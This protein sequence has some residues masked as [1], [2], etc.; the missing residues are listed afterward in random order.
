MLIH[1]I[2]IQ[3][4]KDNVKVSFDN[5]QSWKTY[6]VTENGTHV[7]DIE[8]TK[9]DCSNI[10]NIIIGSSAR[11]KPNATDTMKKYFDLETV[12]TKYTT[13]DDF[14]NLLSTL[15]E[16]SA[17]NPYSIKIK[18][19]TEDN[20]QKIR[21]ALSTINRKIYIDLSPSDLRGC[22]S[23]FD[24]SYFLGEA[25]QELLTGITL[26]EDL[27]YIGTNVF[28]GC[29]NLKAI[30]IPQLVTD[31]G[32]KAFY[33]CI[34]LEEVTLLT[35]IKSIDGHAFDHD[36]DKTSKLSKIT[37]LG[38]LTRWSQVEKEDNDFLANAENV[39]TIT[40]E[41]TIDNLEEFLNNMESSPND[42]IP[43]SVGEVS[44]ADELKKIN[45][46][47][48]NAKAFVDLSSLDLS[49]FKDLFEG[50][51]NDDSSGIFDTDVK[52]YIVSLTV[53]ENVTSIGKYVFSD[54]RNMT[55]VFFGSKIEEIKQGAFTNCSSLTETA[56]PKSLTKIGFKA[57]YNCKNIRISC[58]YN[59]SFTSFFKDTSID[60]SN[61]YKLA[62]PSS[63]KRIE[64]GEFENC[65]NLV[66]ITIPESVIDIGERAFKNCSRLKT[67]E[68][69]SGVK[70]IS[71]S[72]FEGCTYLKSVKLPVTLEK[73]SEAAFY[74]CINLATIIWKD[75]NKLVENI[76]GNKL[77][78]IE[79]FAFKNCKS[80]L[81][82]DLSKSNITILPEGCFTNC[83]KITK[84]VLPSTLTSIN[85]KAFYS[86]VS[87]SN[88]SIPNNVNNIG[89]YVFY[90]TSIKNFTFPTSLKTLGVGAFKRTG[91]TEISL[92]EGFTN[93]GEEC[94]ME[95]KIESIQL[96]QSLKYIDANAF[97]GCSNLKE[98]EL[99][100][101]V[102]ELG[103]YAFANCTSLGNV[104]IPS[105]ITGTKKI[106]SFQDDA[107]NDIDDI[108]IIRMPID[109]GVKSDGIGLPKTSQT[110]KD[111]L[112]IP[113][114][115]DTIPNN[116]FTECSSIE[117]V[118]IPENIKT[119]GDNA[120]ENCTN[121]KSIYLPKSIE[122]I[123]FNAFYYCSNLENVYYQGTEEEWKEL[124]TGWYDVVVK[125]SDGTILKD[126]NNNEL[127]EKGIKKYIKAGNDNLFKENIVYH[128]NTVP[129]GVSA[130]TY[131]PA[132]YNFT[133]KKSYKNYKFLVDDNNK[134]LS[135]SQVY[136]LSGYTELNTTVYCFGIGAFYNCPNLC[137]TI[138]YTDELANYFKDSGISK[139]NGLK[140]FVPKDVKE[141]PNGI[142]K[143][144][145]GLNNVTFDPDIKLEKIGEY[146]FYNCYSISS[147]IIPT[148]VTYIGKYAFKGCKG[149]KSIELNDITKVIREGTF[150]GC[151]NLKD[152]D[153]PEQL[154][155]IET[156]AFYD[157]TSLEDITFY[158]SLKEI[159]TNA[160]YNCKNVRLTCEYN[161]YYSDG[162][163]GWQERS[164]YL[165]ESGLTT[166]NVYKLILPDKI[167]EIP[168]DEFINEETVLHGLPCQYKNL[169]SIV[170]TKNIKKIG[171]RAFAY[172]SNL[173][174]III[175][176]DCVITEICEDAFLECNSLITFN[177]T[178]N[179]IEIG[180]DAFSLCGFKE[181]NLP[182]SIIN[183]D[184]GA[185]SGCVNLKKIKMPKNLTKISKNLFLGDTSLS[186][187]EI[188]QNV[189]YYGEECFMGCTSLRDFTLR[190]N[191]KFVGKDAF[192]FCP[193]IRLNCYYNQYWDGIYATKGFSSSQ[194]Y[195]IN[196]DN[197]M[198]EIPDYKF[199]NFKSLRKVTFY[200]AGTS[201]IKNIG[202]GAFRGCTSLFETE[203]PRSCNTIQDWAYAESG[204]V[205]LKFP[206]NLKRIAANVCFD[207][208]DLETVSFDCS[209]TE[210]C[211]NA[212]KKCSKLKTITL[213]DSIRIMGKGL[214][215]ECSSLE[216]INIPASSGNI[217]DNCFYKCTSLKNIS[218]GNNTTII[219]NGT[220]SGCSS[221][222]SIRLPDNLVE[223]DNNCFEDCIKLKNINI[224]NT[225]N[226]IGARAFFNCL[227]L[228]N[229]S[230]PSTLTE[231]RF[232]TF[233]NCSA[234]GTITIPTNVEKV[235]GNVFANCSSLIIN[236]GSNKNFNVSYNGKMITNKD[237]TTLFAFI[238]YTTKT[239][240]IP[241]T[242]KKIG[243]GALKDCFKLVSV[244]IPNG[245]EYIDEYSF[246]GCINLQKITLP[247][248]ILRIGKAAFEN[249]YNLG[250]VPSTGIFYKGTEEKWKNIKINRDGNSVIV[251]P[252]QIN[253]GA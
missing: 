161:N 113:R 243:N 73:I 136:D 133:R 89:D 158:G 87:L 72:T 154:E 96:P 103:Y 22:P 97:N 16:N 164:K 66:G 63:L 152:I 192:A 153:Y 247:T 12:N 35:S 181:V 143:N 101:G 233:E 141:L 126:K 75:G 50:M 106:V 60:K 216:S 201:V 167:T 94:F 235:E 226:E 123:D 49:K 138:T 242:I 182:D 202:V 238:D 39:E 76:A 100:E 130:G 137:I 33:N 57:F 193:D 209:P 17:S 188:P 4:T 13:P 208:K 248:T 84:I 95:S 198:T 15:S 196:V 99:K 175:P 21:E 120:F 78:L 36:A 109:I 225:V 23:I 102:E 189:T 155:I 195:C 147:L 150:E 43:I 203:P 70:N 177:F 38:S 165:G 145:T 179:L 59:N 135:V 230:L 27:T 119:I 80:L 30:S 54:Y 116:G 41:T 194:V 191:V 86:C 218:I 44:T 205:N 10:S 69:P 131:N 231:L 77:K 37:Y 53:P 47:L 173:K 252:I 51:D 124:S 25:Y 52:Q 180:N 8:F 178:K 214:F 112:F 55:T 148:T 83:S 64:K 18:G 184:S 56:F 31:I 156:R 29:I 151:S 207:C 6:S 162:Q 3:T 221:L 174:E 220:F 200:K 5:G 224:P 163:S 11:H 253:F 234:L 121:L 227:S 127:K 1:F 215:Q 20:F 185:F 115:T 122:K 128:Y 58:E 213:P 91:L 240:N 118:I 40:Y 139:E 251:D 217:S 7:D 241:N 211:E 222:E 204:I 206:V 61:V 9:K 67:I 170:L 65:S 105:S 144:Y 212:F 134:A 32:R 46:A 228:S 168:A 98:L 26:P 140:I 74:N 187:I 219:G 85:N 93:I 42:P 19:L 166:H 229:I 132:N 199:E 129:F 197:L 183:I 108:L 114:N 210:T 45:V 142:F 149:L 28:N 2:K 79:P 81:S 160:F 117:H 186:S 223:I 172:C 34:S 88:I 157:C 245:V 236:I 176:D 146:A 244:D 68:V 111:V 249:C 159:G 169:G 71:A 171:E 250:S 90:D 92:P 246:K 104:N 24:N 239:V 125:A 62:L 14:K 107:F 48:R 237:N 232:G 190:N 110:K 82:V